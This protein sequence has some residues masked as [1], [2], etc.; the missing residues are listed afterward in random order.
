MDMWEPYVQSTLAHLDGAAAK[1]VLDKFHVEKH[2]HEAVDKVRKAERRALRQTEADRL[3]GTWYLWLMLPKDMRP[4]QPQTFQAPKTSELDVAWALKEGFRQFRGYVY[5]GAARTFFTRWFWHA[6][7]SR[8][9]PMAKLAWLMRP[10]FAN[11]LTYLK[12]C[13]INAG[14]E[15]VNATIQ[16]VNKTARG[17]R[18]IE[19][20][21]TAIYFHSGGPDPYPHE[22]Q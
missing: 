7:H 20:F 11:I 18:N 2:I 17:F 5:S 22:S 15:A 8:L 16:W 10:H 6:T 14:L 1:V 3:T 9:A 19:H 21:K 12:H 4:A 13:I